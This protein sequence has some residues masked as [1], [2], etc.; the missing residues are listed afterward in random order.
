M[1]V[2]WWGLFAPSAVP[3][4]IV[5]RIHADVVRV[6]NTPSVRASI[7]SQGGTAAPS[8]QA[9]LAE[10]VRNETARWGQL[11]RERGIRAN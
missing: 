10:L 9:E 7:E 6:L 1:V 4:P 8:T 2:P 11:I 3:D 5:R